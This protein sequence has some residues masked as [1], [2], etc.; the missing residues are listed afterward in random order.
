MSYDKY[1][2]TYLLTYVLKIEVLTFQTSQKRKLCV[3]R[4]SHSNLRLKG[5]VYVHKGKLQ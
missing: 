1:A 3:Q 5:D 4:L 2:S